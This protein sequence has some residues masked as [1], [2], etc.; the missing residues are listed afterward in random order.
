MTARDDDVI[1]IDKNQKKIS[2][3]PS[4]EERRVKLGARKSHCDK[5]TAEAR[6][7]GS[8][9]LFEAIDTAVKLAYMIGTSEIDEP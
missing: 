3:D 2:P 8:H 9:S 4:E 7:S 6:K 1:H 5:I